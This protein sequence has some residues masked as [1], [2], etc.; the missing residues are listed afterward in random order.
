VAQSLIYILFNELHLQIYKFDGESGEIVYVVFSWVNAQWFYSRTYST[1]YISFGGLL[2]S[3]TG[4]YRHMTS[5]VL[6]DPI[7]LLMRK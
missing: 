3:L 7:Y 5:I 2:M 4:S 6:G 1:A